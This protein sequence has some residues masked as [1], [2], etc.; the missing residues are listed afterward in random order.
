MNDP[1]VYNYWVETLLIN[2][3]SKLKSF[4]WN[5]RDGSVN[6]HVKIVLIDD[7]LK[8]KLSNLIKLKLIKFSW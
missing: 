6:S 8:T 3:V 1:I 5:Q 7:L 2:D 4:I